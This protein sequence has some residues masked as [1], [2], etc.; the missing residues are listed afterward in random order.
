MT[1]FS[2]GDW[3]NAWATNTPGQSGDPRSPHY[4][5]LFVDW[6]HDRYFPLLFERA[7][8]E[9]ETEQRIVLVARP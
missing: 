1:L 8:V 2:L 6:A 9:K 4:R 7:A 5:D 3:S